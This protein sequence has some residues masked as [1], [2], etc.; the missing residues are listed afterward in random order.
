VLP[1]KAIIGAALAL[2]SAAAIFAPSASATKPCP[3]GHYCT[4]P[5][6]EYVLEVE[7]ISP[8]NLLL[9]AY[10]DCV[11]DAH[12]EFGDGTSG[13]YVFDA[14]VGI[15]GSHVFPTPGTTYTVVVDLSDGHHGQTKDP[16]PDYSRSAKVL[17]RT[18]AEEADDPPPWVPI[19][20]GGTVPPLIPVAPAT[21]IPNPW[22][23]QPPPTPESN[24]YWR[25]CGGGVLTHLVTCKKGRRVAKA[26]SGR[27]TRP[28]TA[29]VNGFT[30]RLRGSQQSAVC[31]RGEQIVRAP[32]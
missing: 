17:Y 6:G 15:T 4:D 18:P 10:A 24:A 31:R 13:D 11:W 14:A 30:C 25:S 26:A 29:Q 27:L 5:S 22:T 1:G 9:G 16:C 19:D 20:Q 12:V 7:P 28:G 23:A 21:Q 8:N 3:K 2:L 32:G